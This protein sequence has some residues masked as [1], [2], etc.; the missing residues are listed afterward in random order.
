MAAVLAT[1]VPEITIAS[2]RTISADQIVRN[3][4]SIFTEPRHQRLC[5]AG[6]IS[7]SADY[8]FRTK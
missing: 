8:T 5:L 3:V 2:Q 1:V 7:V 4:G 6:N